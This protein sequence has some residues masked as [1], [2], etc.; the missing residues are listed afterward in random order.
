MHLRELQIEDAE[1]M[2]EWMTDNC[3]T[4]FFHTDFSKK[5]IDDAYDFIKHCND[6]EKHCKYFA[7]ASDENTYMGTVALKNYDPDRQ[8]IEFSIVVRDIAMGKGYAWFGTRAAIEKAF[9]EYDVACVYW[10][11]KRTNRRAIQFFDKHGFR[12]AVDVPTEIRE[13]Y[14]QKADL[15]WYSV[16]KDD[17]LDDTFESVNNIDGCSIVRINTIPTIG[18]GELSFFESTN[19]FGF[20]T[21]RIYYISK[22]PEGQRRG[23]HAHKELKQL[24][25]CPYGRVEIR[26]D[27]GQKHGEIIL[28]DPSVGIFI[29]KPIWREMLWLVKDSVLCIAA[30]DY[31]KEDDY[32]RDYFSFKKYRDQM[33]GR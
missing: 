17:N 27:D 6:D 7:I 18:A 19:E 4:G 21:K 28:S 10:E 24:L 1:L 33:N 31:Y 16:L 29:D 22:V 12:E 9:S 15:K 30:S 26:L 13:R 5:K 32:I 23:Y 25:F 11:V 14:P 3:I 8:H 2:Y 20:D